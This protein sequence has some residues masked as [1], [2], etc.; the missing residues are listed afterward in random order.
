MQVS[1]HLQRILYLLLDGGCVPAHHQR[2]EPAEEL[3]QRCLGLFL[4]QRND[5]HIAVIELGRHRLEQRGLRQRLVGAARAAHPGAHTGAKKHAQR[6]TQDAQHRA[7]Q[8]A[9]DGGVTHLLERIEGVHR[10]DDT[11]LLLDQ[12]RLG[13][14]RVVI[15][16]EGLQLHEG[17]VGLAGYLE[18]GCQYVFHSS[19]SF[20]CE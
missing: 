11:V 10:C 12:R 18:Q 16:R 20:L 9:G 17:L 8:R 15:L 4:R 2:L 13:N 1:L 6:A 3:V 19:C 5:R 7:D 14:A